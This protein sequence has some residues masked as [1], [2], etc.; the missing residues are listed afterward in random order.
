M[1]GDKKH[2]HVFKC[3]MQWRQVP[4]GL[5]TAVFIALAR[6]AAV[7]CSTMGRK[8][9]QHHRRTCTMYVTCYGYMYMYLESYRDQ[10][11]SIKVNKL[12]Y[13]HDI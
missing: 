8:T 2:V 9:N 4:V 12:T 3:I 5:L 6:A 13:L 11:K 10:G 7:T 1:E